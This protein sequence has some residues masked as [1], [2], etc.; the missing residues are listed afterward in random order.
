MPKAL[1]ILVLLA[2]IH[3]L[4]AQQET[5]EPPEQEEEFRVRVRVEL[6]TAPLVVQNRQGE[7]VYDLRREEVTVLDNGVP[8]QITAFELA[9]QPIS[10]VILA[11][12]SQRIAA[13]VH[14]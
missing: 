7:F 9:S 4:G 2:L 11:D 5:T 14:L 6:V 13:G 1:S 10:L 12:T 8:Q 3:P